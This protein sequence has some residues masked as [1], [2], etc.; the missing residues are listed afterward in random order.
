MTA[1]ILAQKKFWIVKPAAGRNEIWNPRFDPPEGIA[2]WK[3]WT[4]YYYFAIWR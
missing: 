1:P 4:L 3:W 2:Y